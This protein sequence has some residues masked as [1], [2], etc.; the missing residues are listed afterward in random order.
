MRVLMIAW[1]F[2]QP[3]TDD[4]PRGRIAAL[5]AALSA[6]GHSVTVVTRHVPGLPDVALCAGV[7]VVRA[8]TLEDLRSALLT[9]LLLLLHPVGRSRHSAVDGPIVSRGR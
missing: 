9:H 3:S 1:E 4:A 8:R 6:A 2:Q 7:R 5:S